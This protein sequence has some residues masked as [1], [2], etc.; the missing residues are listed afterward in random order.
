MISI[1]RRK[2]KGDRELSMGLP[3]IFLRTHWGPHRHMQAVTPNALAFPTTLLII[4]LLDAT[5]G[6]E[7]VR[8][9]AKT[10]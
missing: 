5:S 8:N 1:H 7:T 4:C 2:I 9:E 6:E 10:Q 3:A